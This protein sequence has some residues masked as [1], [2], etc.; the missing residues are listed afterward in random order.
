LLAALL[1]AWAPGV[2]D[3][4]HWLASLSGFEYPSL[5]MFYVLGPCMLIAGLPSWWI[6]GGYIRWTSRLQNEDAGDWLAD[7]LRAFRGEK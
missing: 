2:L 5:S 4:A 7:A 3:S 6:I 1:I